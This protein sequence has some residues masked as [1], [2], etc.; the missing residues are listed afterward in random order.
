MKFKKKIFWNEF[1]N[2]FELYIGAVLFL[3]M[4]VLLTW[5]VVT[6]YLARAITW[7]E[8]LSCIMLVWMSYLGFAGAITTRKHLRI[9]AFVNALP[10]KVKKIVLIL[11]N[12]INAAFA[13]MLISPMYNVMMSFQK[14]DATSPILKIPKVFTFSILPV[15][16]IL[17][18]IRTL[19]ECARLAGEEEKTLGVGK[20]A[21]DLDA[22]AREG[23]ME[24]EGRE[25]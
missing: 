20:P 3:A 15:S 17:I 16:M 18:L 14:I 23:E 1:I 4:M 24:R 9:D 11:S 25:A 6:R 21:L 5:Q 8:E 22:I 10:F 7:T 19:Q 2:R 12:L 13:A